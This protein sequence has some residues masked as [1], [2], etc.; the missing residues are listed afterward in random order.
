M[1]KRNSLKG[2]EMR[3]EYAFSS[4]RGGVRGKY[5]KR[6][7]A[8]ANLVLLD[9]EVAKAFPTD[10]AVNEALRTVLRATTTH[11]RATKLPN[12]GMQQTSAA[13]AHRRRGAR[14]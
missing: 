10:T 14:S 3:A 11:W 2:D 4:M 6:Y 9:P 8:G 5:F 12:K 7:R 13:R 1:K